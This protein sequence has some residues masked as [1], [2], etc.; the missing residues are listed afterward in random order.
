M[1][2]FKQTSLKYFDKLVSDFL[3]LKCLLLMDFVV[4]GFYSDCWLRQ[5]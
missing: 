4:M 2:N 1:F 5:Q 3:G